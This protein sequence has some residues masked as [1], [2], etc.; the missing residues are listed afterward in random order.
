[1]AADR[2]KGGLKFLYAA[3]EGL[4]YLSDLAGKLEGRSS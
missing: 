3:I 4:R 2:G 1:M